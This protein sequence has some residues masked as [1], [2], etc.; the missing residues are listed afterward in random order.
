MTFLSIK[1]SFQIIRCFIAKFVQQKFS[2]YQYNEQ[3]VAYSAICVIH[4]F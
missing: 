1:L 3:L 4:I 2:Y